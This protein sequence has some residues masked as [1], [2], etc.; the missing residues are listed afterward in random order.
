MKITKPGLNMSVHVVDMTCLLCLTEFEAS[1]DPKA[2]EALVYDAGDVPPEGEARQLRAHCA[3]PN[4]GAPVDHT[5]RL[6]EGAAKPKPMI[7]GRM[8]MPDW[9]TL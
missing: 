2:K 9:R 5:V 8:V 6:R 3:C 1:A 4:C 7:S